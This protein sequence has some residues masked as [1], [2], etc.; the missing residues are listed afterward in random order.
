M[1]KILFLLLAYSTTIFAAE[2]LSED[3]IVLFTPPTNWQLADSTNLPKSVKVMVVGKAEAHFPPSMNL[4]TEPYTGTLKQY[5]KLI[6]SINDSQGYDWKDL[7]TIKTKAGIASLSQVDTKNEWGTVRQMHVVLLKGGHIYILTAAAIKEDFPRYYKD[8]FD[9]FHSLRVNQNIFEMVTTT[10][11]RTKLQSAIDKLNKDWQIA[12]TQKQQSAP[13]T[14]V[15]EIRDDVFESQEFQTK[16]WKPFKEV[17]ERDYK[18]MGETWQGF[19]ISKAED[20]LYN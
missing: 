2:S 9:A 8:F 17:I 18:D 3:P 10:E 16:A 1:K 11:K 6:K 5:L 4:S 7:G 19:I 20:D 13:E 15:K 14:P 12:V